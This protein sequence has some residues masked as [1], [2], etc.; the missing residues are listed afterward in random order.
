MNRANTPHG[1]IEYRFEGSGK[2]VVLMLYGGHTNAQTHLGEDYFLGRGYKVLVVSR[3]GYGSTPLSTGRTPDEFADALAE[4]LKELGIARVLV[5]G[6]SAGGRTAM[7]FAA[8]HAAMT[9]ALILQSSI[10]FAP[11]PDVMTRLGSYI[12]FNAI[13]EK[14]TWK[15]MHSMLRKNPMALARRVISSLT[16]LD[17]GKVVRD[18]TKEQQQEVTDLFAHMNSGSGFLND[19]RTASNDATDVMVPTLIIHSKYDKSVPLS[20]PRLLAKQIKGAELYLSEAESHLIWFSPHYPEIQ[21]VM[22]DFL[23]RH[24][25]RENT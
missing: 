25:E 16:I 2:H 7:R 3:P 21:D 6:I 20:H 11:W 8:R 23:E 1:D 10:S 4:L 15:I 14:Y 18:F 24:G 9:R 22:D 19:I 5:V 12:G 17:A 13:T